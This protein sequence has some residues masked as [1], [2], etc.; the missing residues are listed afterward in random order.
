M[1]R[2]SRDFP[3]FKGSRRLRPAQRPRRRWR[4]RRG[5]MLDLGPIGDGHQEPVLAL[6]IL[7]RIARRRSGPGLPP[8]RSAPGGS[9]RRCTG[10]SC[11][12]WMFK[13]QASVASEESWITHGHHDRAYNGEFASSGELALFSTA[14]ASPRRRVMAEPIPATEVRAVLRT[15]PRPYTTFSIWRFGSARSAIGSMGVKS[16]SPQ[17][18]S[19]PVG[20]LTTD[21]RSCR[22]RPSR[23]ACPCRAWRASSR[24][25]RPG[26]RAPIAVGR[27]AA[28]VGRVAINLPVDPAV[29]ARDREEVRVHGPRAAFVRGSTGCGGLEADPV[30]AGRKRPRRALRNTGPRHA[31]TLTSYAWSVLPL[32][33]DRLR[34]TLLPVVGLVAA[35]IP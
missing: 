12:G 11:R 8:H 10:Q 19:A 16:G 26:G 32:R 27:E 5:S 30:E 1:D 20:S 17:R 4:G 23:W 34:L 2:S 35:R 15:L 24:C 31:T 7:R 3:G 33:G 14:I 6:T 9:P 13:G 25:C 29:A 28:R 21:R 22:S 18:W